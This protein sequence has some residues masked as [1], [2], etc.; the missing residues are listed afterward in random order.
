MATTEID[1]LELE[2]RL[3]TNLMQDL[4]QNLYCCTFGKE[5]WCQQD[6]C[7]KYPEKLSQM[8]R[9]AYYGGQIRF[10]KVV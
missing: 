9:Y 1:K 4:T 3:G 2:T 7:E 8:A 6:S 5:N 10:G